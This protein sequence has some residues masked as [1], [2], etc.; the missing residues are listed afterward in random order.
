MSPIEV[1]AL[2][3][4]PA[5]VRGFWLD[6]EMLAATGLTSIPLLR[7]VQ[8]L[9]LLGSDYVAMSVGGRRRVWT[10]TNVLLGQLLVRFSELARMPVQTAA[11]WLVRPPRDWLV[12]AINLKELVE[13]AMDA[14]PDAVAVVGTRFVITEMQDVWFELAP[15]VFALAGTDPTY[16]ADDILGPDTYSIERVLVHVGTALVVDVSAIHLTVSDRVRDERLA[17]LAGVKRAQ[18]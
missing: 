14:P 3:E 1:A 5:S 2:L 7:K 4:Q 6:D 9:G 17:Q 16:E 13:E 10:F 8:G 15:D 12:K 18:S 11:D